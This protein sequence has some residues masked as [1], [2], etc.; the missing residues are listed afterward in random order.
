MNL[1]TR[2]RTIDPEHMQEALEFSVE[3]AQYVTDTTHLKVIPWISVYGDPVGT[4][5][6]SARVESLA[7]MGAAQETLATDAGFQQRLREQGTRYFSGPTQDVIAQFVDMA[8]TAPNTGKFASIVTAQCAGGKIAEAMAW[9][10]DIMNHVAKVADMDVALVRGLYGP[11]ATLG[12]I[13][14]VD[15]L[16]KVDSVEAATSTDPTYIETIDQAGDLFVPGSAQQRLVRRL[17]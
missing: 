10:V 15:S 12:W 3:I 8:G 7:A 14:V 1:F 11:W 4:V 2:T 16:D 13:S 9:G 6:F 17:G 5:S